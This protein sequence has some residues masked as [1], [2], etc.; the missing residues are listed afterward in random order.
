MRLLLG[1]VL[2]GVAV[3]GFG[4]AQGQGGDRPNPPVPSPEFVSKLSVF[5]SKMGR[6]WKPPAGSRGR[7]ISIKVLLKKDGTLSERPVLDGVAKDQIARAM[8]DSAVTAL[9]RCQPYDMFPLADHH[10]WEQII[11]TFAADPEPKAPPTRS[12][13]K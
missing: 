13:R 6:C 9:E 5:R 3:A 7:Q 4:P 2:I 12:D 1:L 8:F 11:L 10:I